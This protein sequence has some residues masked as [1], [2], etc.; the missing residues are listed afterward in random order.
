M[1]WVLLFSTL[2]AAI[3]LLLAWAWKAP[4]LASSNANNGRSNANSP[5]GPDPV[6]MFHAPEPAAVVPP[7]GTDHLAPQQ[8]TPQSK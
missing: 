3:G 8:V 1:L 6:G 5:T 7:P 2:L 4:D